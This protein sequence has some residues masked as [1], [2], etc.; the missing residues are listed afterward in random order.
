MCNIKYYIAE[1]AAYFGNMLGEKV[2]LKP[3]DKD[4][5]ERI[6][7]NVS[8]KFS[9][10][11][12][13]ILGQHILMAY[14][15]DGDSVPP[16]QLKKLLDIIGRQTQLVVVLI[17]PCI[18]SYNKVRLV[19][20]KVNFV[21]PNRQMFLPSLLLDI[22]PDR[23]VG[24]DLKETIPPFAQCLLLYHLQIESIVGT[25]GYGLSD[26]FGVSYATANKSLR[27]LVS[28]DLIKLE[29]TKTKTVQIDISNRELWNKALP[30]LVSP[31]EQ[32]YY[33]RIKD[34]GVVINSERFN[35]EHAKCRAF[36]EKAVSESQ[37]KHIV[38]A[39]HH[40]PSFQLVSPDFK[41]S[42]I[43]GAFTAELGN[44]IAYSRI[45][46]WIYGH[47]H[48][49]IDRIIGNT[50]CVSNQLGYVNHGESESFVSK[51]CINLML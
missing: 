3:A 9:F 30:M 26:K 32:L 7:M 34:C 13:C 44:F 28:K 5:L 4:L 1:T 47:S 8:S 41:G 42:P 21:I 49:N 24:L 38:V 27:W 31:I 19:A 16:A 17:T 15:K 40:V 18:S 51:K 46:Y 50:Q 12:G 2:A 29:G 23:K 36:I 11:K 48:R 22:K 6:P 20:Q 35:Q 10:Y 39:T 37:A 14:L 25:T 43:N 33:Y 45:D